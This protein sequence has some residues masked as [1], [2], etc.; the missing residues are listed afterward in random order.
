M[1][2]DWNS[3]EH[4][5]SQPSRLL[6]VSFTLLSVLFFIHACVCRHAKR[7]LAQIVDRC[8][9]GPGFHGNGESG[10]SVQEMLIPASKVGLVIGRGGDTIKQLQVELRPP[11]WLRLV[12]QLQT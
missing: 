6:R 1:F 3:R 4:R 7:L 2:P 11:I 5:V 8:R 12:D 9:N 10:N